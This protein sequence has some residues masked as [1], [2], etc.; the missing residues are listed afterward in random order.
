MSASNI[1]GSIGV[2]LLLVA[3]FLN[4]FKLLPPGS[5]MYGVLNIIG[6]GLACF[7]SFMIGFIPFVVLEGIWA[8]VALAGMFRKST[9]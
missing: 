2:A 1:I 3:Y 4:L 9:R 7:A 8:I 5:K 6:A